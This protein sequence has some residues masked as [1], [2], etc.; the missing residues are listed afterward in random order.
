MAITR[1]GEKRFAGIVAVGENRTAACDN[2]RAAV[3]N[4]N[5]TLLSESSSVFVAVAGVQPEKSYS[6]ITGREATLADSSLVDSLESTSSDIEHADVFVSVCT[7]GCSQVIVSDAHYQPDYCPSCS[8]A[9]PELDEHETIN[10]LSELESESFDDNLNGD[11]MSVKGNQGIVVV[12]DSLVDAQDLFA[13]ASS[14]ENQ[15]VYLADG[16]AQFVTHASSDSEFSPFN[17]E[18]SEIDDD[19]DEFE[20]ESVS[21]DDGDISAH[22]LQCLASGCGAHVIT[23]SEEASY[24]PRCSSGLVDPEVL[25]SLA[26]DSDL[27]GDDDEDDDLALDLDFDDEDDSLESDSSDEDLDDIDDIDDI[28]DLED[29]DD[30]DEDDL[31]FESDSSFDDEEDD[32]FE[33]DSS[34]DD[35]EEDDEDDEDEDDLEDDLD[36][37]DD[38]EDLEDLD[39]LDDD[40]DEEDDF[41]SESSVEVE[42][43]FFEAYAG[44]DE[45]AHDASLL[46][47]AYCGNIQ[48]EPTWLAFYNGYPVARCLQSNSSAP[49]LFANAKFGEATRT[50]AQSQGI[51]TALADMGYEML[52]PD[53]DLGVSVSAKMQ[54]M[55]EAELADIQEQTQ[56]AIT[57]VEGRFQAALATS[58]MAINRNVV[59]G[60]TNP[61]AETLIAS[62]SAVGLSNAAELVNSAFEQRSDAYVKE[63]VSLASQQVAKP[64]ESQND[65]AQMVS[66]ASFL[67]SSAATSGVD[68]IGR[69][70]AS[71]SA[72]NLISESSAADEDQTPDFH[73]K[74]AS[75]LSSL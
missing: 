35:D 70:L 15:R 20:L 65:F 43:N 50:A 66:Q 10:A 51:T 11:E 41:D 17:G 59:R 32:E 39:D 30:L 6:P 13:E 64:L 5:M 22:Y 25:S 29:L 58:S 26:G 53:V 47:V 28:D 2:F 60:K 40:E 45:E 62:L 75:L 33:A 16:E 21:N 23:S 71:E 68:D 27:D 38:D 34:D 67:S 44:L 46:S 19:A 4:Q 9:L 36:D 18:S 37:L 72:Q 42:L 49:E 8:S 7:D 48:G 74:S 52:K 1:R 56:N 57:E 69:S 63:I 55:H 3:L 31:D 24:C 14:D 54:R 61:I 73:S 12:A